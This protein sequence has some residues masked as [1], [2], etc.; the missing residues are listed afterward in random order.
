[1][2]FRQKSVFLRISNQVSAIF[3]EGFKSRVSRHL[4]WLEKTD[5]YCWFDLDAAGFEMLNMMRQHYPNATS[6]LMDER[7]FKDFQVFA[8]H[9]ES[10]QRVRYLE[11]LTEKEQALYQNI[12]DY[13]WRL[14]Q[15][16]VSQAH[17][18]KRLNELFTQAK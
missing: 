15:E 6:F 16:R 2:K 13:N 12:I 4:P 7:T 8:V 17:V 11:R 14:E 9:P 1:M 10:R 3:G 18:Q 5:L